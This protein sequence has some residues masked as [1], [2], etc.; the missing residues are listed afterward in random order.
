MNDIAR[1][2]LSV[3]QESEYLEHVGVAHDENPPGRGSGRYAYGSGENRYQRL[4]KDFYNQYLDL[5]KSGMKEKDIAKELGCYDAKGNPSTGVLRDMR[6]VAKNNTRK[7]EVRRAHELRDQGYTLQQ[8]ADELG[9]P[10]ESSVRSLLNGS[11]ETNMLRAEKTAEE[12]KRVLEE[13]GK[14]IDIGTGV[15]AELSMAMNM[16]IS[17]TRLS[18]ALYL[19][20]QEGY[21]VENVLMPQV[22]NLNGQK[23]TIRVLAPPGT[24]IRELRDYSNIVPY[25]DY[26]SH[27]NG[28]T[29]KKAVE[30]P[31]SLDPKRLMIRYA[32]D[33]GVDKDG[34]IELRR[35]VQDLDLKG[36][37]YCQTRIMVNGTHYL[38]GMAVYGDNFPPGI[39]VIFNTNK[40]KDVPVMGPKD[41]SVL[42]PIK[43]DPEN[44]FGSLIKDK[45]RGGQYDYIDKETGE[46]KLGL[47]NKTRDEGEWNEWSDS[48]PSQFISKQPKALIDRQLNLTIA[49]KNAELDDIMT[50]TNPTLRKKFLL[51]FAGKCDSTA[52]DLKAAKLPG[53][54]YRVILPLTTIK[55]S[56]IYAPNLK[57][58]TMVALVRFPHAGP[59]EIPILRVN[60]N[61]QEGDRVITKNS[62]DAV[63]IT[64]KTADILSGADFDGDTVLVIPMSDRVRINSRAHD[65]AFKELRDFDPQHDYA[66]RPGMAVLTEDNK[67]REMGIISNLITDMYTRGADDKDLIAA[68]KHSMVVIDAVKHNLDYKRSEQENHIK[69]LKAKYQKHS[70]DDKF[71]GASTIISQA[72]S[73]ARVTKRQGQ[74]RIDKKTGEISYR[75]AD[76]AVY[77][78]KKGQRVEKTTTVSKMEKAFLSGGNAFDLVSDINNPV[79]VAYA[80]FANTMHDI[81]KKARYTAVNTQGVTYSKSA[82]LAFKDDVDNLLEQV[83]KA[84]LNRPRERAAQTLANAKRQIDIERWK[85]AHPGY[86][87]T[88][89]KNYMK[90]YKKKVATKSL[91]NSRATVGAARSE[92]ILTDRQWQAINLNAIN[93]TN[94]NK[95]FKY[96]NMDDVRARALPRN[97]QSLSTAKLAKMKAMRASGYSNAEI[98]ESLDVSVSTVTNYIKGELA[99]TRLS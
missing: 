54:K 9:K 91:T 76:D 13:R 38:K 70:Y 61:N 81:A 20:K 34:V 98:A 51:D 24:D 29:I 5:K 78:N 50:V 62:L 36:S 1:A 87:N 95:I 28:D 19:L 3:L 88:E 75:R 59:H 11:S 79:E 83:R 46:K 67:Q 52:E 2:M 66:A 32:E 25:T 85:E 15:E 86:S 96:A 10:N 90:E 4:G 47:I 26:I 97:D 55:D 37:H 48:A 80:K 89:Y 42:K 23:T 60:N 72:G 35:G 33:G 40:T 30:Y 44:P 12:L 71:G 7:E 82:Y 31:A 6:A 58:G 68:T 27:D 74:A 41:N 56:E 77:I 21:V 69:E 99:T 49:D 53:Q 22:T 93:Q 64:K 17:E 16:N 84:E 8:I 18:E 39:D 57:D 63:G 92:I 73:D 14:F 65:I 45:D 43:D 94:L